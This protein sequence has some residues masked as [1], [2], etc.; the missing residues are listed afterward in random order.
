M[1]H[2]V[3]LLCPLQRCVD[4]HLGADGCWR[5]SGESGA[6][7]GATTDVEDVLRSSAGGHALR[8]PPPMEELY[9]G[10]K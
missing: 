9:Q 7:P 2:D 8:V 10:A 1:L 3:L 6:K 4:S 5:E